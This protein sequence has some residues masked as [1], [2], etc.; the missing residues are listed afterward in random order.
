MADE[1]LSADAAFGFLRDVCTRKGFDAAVQAAQDMMR[2]GPPGSRR[3]MDRTRRFSPRI[4]FRKIGSGP[5]R[6]R[7]SRHLRRLS[8]SSFNVRRIEGILHRITLF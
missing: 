1:H 7:A 3:S 4:H 5:G 6:S 2:P 8:Q